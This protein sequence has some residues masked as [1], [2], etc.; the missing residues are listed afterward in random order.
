VSEITEHGYDNERG[1]AAIERINALHGRFR[2]SNGDFLYVLSSF[3]YEPIRWI[4]RFAW[5]PMREHERLALFYFWREVGQR[6]SIHSLRT[7]TTDSS[8]STPSMNGAI[9]ATRKRTLASGL[10]REICLW[11]GSPICRVRWCG[12]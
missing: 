7:T 6:M 12:V 4:A 11:A 10:L 1:R 9:S 2:I 5:R 3:I 8:D